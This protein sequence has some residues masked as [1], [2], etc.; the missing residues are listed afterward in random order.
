MEYK[1][2]KQ[3]KEWIKPELKSLRFKQTF[4]GLQ[5]SYLEITGGAIS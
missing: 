2:K 4:G 5:T 3:K 1:A